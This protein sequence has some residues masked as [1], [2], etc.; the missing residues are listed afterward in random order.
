MRHVPGYSDGKDND[1][2]VRGGAK[3]ASDFSRLFPSAAG[4]VLFMLWQLET[5]VLCNL[6]PHA[7]LPVHALALLLELVVG[8]TKL[9]NGLF[10]EELLQRPL[11]KVLSLILSQLSNVGHCTLQDGALV[12]LASGH[13]LGQLVD[14][15][16]DGLSPSSLD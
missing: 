10:G 8:R 4:V 9:L 12:F 13:N 14:P 7:Q 11:L 3:C 15:L 16:V 2:T 5:S 6:L 1:K